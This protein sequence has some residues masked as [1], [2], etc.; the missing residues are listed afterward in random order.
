MH[1]LGNITLVGL[2][3][4]NL[5]MR[6]RSST[7]LT[8]LN[9]TS[10]R[11]YTH[12]SIKISLHVTDTIVTYRVARFCGRSLFVTLL[13]LLHR[14][15][16]CTLK[17][18]PGVLNAITDASIERPRQSISCESMGNQASFHVLVCRCFAATV[19]VYDRTASSGFS[20]TSTSRQS[21]STPSDKKTRYTHSTS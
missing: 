18:N 8:L 5:R 16:S 11:S 13:G 1:A 10:C 7:L 21:P 4:S 15:L 2:G 3:K 12:L 19:Q 14:K 20:H 17:R 9:V 6:T